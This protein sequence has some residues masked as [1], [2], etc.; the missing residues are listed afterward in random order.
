MVVYFSFAD[1]SVYNKNR[2]CFFTTHAMLPDDFLISLIN[3]TQYSFCLVLVWR[4]LNAPFYTIVELYFFSSSVIM[5][6]ILF[7]FEKRVPLILQVCQLCG[8][9]SLPIIGF[10][11]T[12]TAMFPMQVRPHEDGPFI[13]I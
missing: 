10:N 11:K 12:V 6:R 13:M 3:S 5:D 8:I 7:K 9:H 2:G 1:A 4:L